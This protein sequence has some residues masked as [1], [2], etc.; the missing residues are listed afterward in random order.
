MDYA[1]NVFDADSGKMLKYWQLLNDPQ[2]QAVWGTLSANE[3]G[4]LAQGIGNRIK[5][6]DTI[7]FV[8]KQQVPRD[9]MKDVTYVKFVCELKPNKKEIH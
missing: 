1:N 9:R 6:T 4:R 7:F 3:L 5:G 2:H 8:H